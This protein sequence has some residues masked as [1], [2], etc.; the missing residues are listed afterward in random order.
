M[1]GQLALGGGQLLRGCVCGGPGGLELHLHLPPGVLRLFQLEACVLGVL[2]RRRHL[3]LR[4]LRFA[5]RLLLRLFQG[6]HVR[7]ERLQ[8]ARHFL[9]L[10]LVLLLRLF[11]GLHLRLQRVHLL[12]LGFQRFLLL[13]V[14]LRGAALQLLEVRPEQLHLL[15]RLG[16]RL[17]GCA[18]LR[19]ALL[20][21]RHL[22][23]VLLLHLLAA[24]LQ[25]LHLP[26]LRGQRVLRCLHLLLELRLVRLYFLLGDLGS[27]VR[28]LQ[29]LLRGRACRARAR[30]R[31]LA[32]RSVPHLRLRLRQ[33][34]LILEV[35]R[36]ELLVL[37]LQHLARPLLL[38]LRDFLLLLLLQLLHL[39]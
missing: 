9:V 1:L 10:C 5:L 24:C 20:E 12:L 7:P 31:A 15:A 22:L 18:Q 25:L 30:A 36:F 11:Q 16:L 4:G 17:L 32:R 33:H 21:L 27:L 14:W 2:P 13:G 19:L 8:L 39:G 37:R 29:L 38:Q 3:A 34:F 28:R 35:V 26:L 23:L 6:L